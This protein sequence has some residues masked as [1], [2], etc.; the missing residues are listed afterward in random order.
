VAL[1]KSPDNSGKAFCVWNLRE[2]GKPRNLSGRFTSL[3]FD[4]TLEIERAATP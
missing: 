4:P 3:R 1:L 2:G